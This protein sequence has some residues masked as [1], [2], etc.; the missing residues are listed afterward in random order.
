MYYNIY[1]NKNTLNVETENE[2]STKLICKHSP[3]I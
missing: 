2:R 1:E 3:M